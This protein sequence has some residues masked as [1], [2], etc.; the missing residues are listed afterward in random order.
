MSKQILSMGIEPR[1]WSK[2]KAFAVKD[3][4]ADKNLETND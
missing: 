1:V 3:I 4:G 2:E